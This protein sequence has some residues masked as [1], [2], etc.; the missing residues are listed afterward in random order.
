M[1]DLYAINS[2]EI[3]KKGEIFGILLYHINGELLKYILTHKATSS[4]I[5]LLR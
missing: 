5:H 3:I 2:F 1:R 4:S